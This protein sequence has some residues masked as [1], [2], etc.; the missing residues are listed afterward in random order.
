MP[1]AVNNDDDVLH[2]TKNT[3]SSDEIQ[4][5]Y[6]KMKEQQFVLFVATIKSICDV[7]VFSNNPGIDLWTKYSPTKSK[8]HEGIH[9]CC[10][11]ISACTVLYNTFPN[12]KKITMSS[13][14]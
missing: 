4:K 8:L 2:T 13:T 3:S 10:G 11:I 6:K 5:Q 1:T 14:K 7:I 12:K 9:C